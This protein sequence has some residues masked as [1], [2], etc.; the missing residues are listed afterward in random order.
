M[1]VLGLSGAVGHDPSA[2]KT[3]CLSPCLPAGWADTAMSQVRTSL[4]YNLAMQVRKLS[5]H[6]KVWPISFSVGKFF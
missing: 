3:A 6:T 5:F 4:E 1:I 2:A